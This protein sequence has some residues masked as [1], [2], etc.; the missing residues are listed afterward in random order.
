[1]IINGYCIPFVMREVYFHRSVFYSWF[2]SVGDC[3]YC[4]MSTQ[5]S[6]IA[7]PRLAKRTKE[8]VLAE[9][10]ICKAMNWKLEFL[11]GGYGIYSF[12]E[13]LDLFKDVYEIMG[14]KLWLNVGTLNDKQL[15]SALPYIEGV[16][17]T[18]ESVN[19]KIR[20][21]MCPSKPMSE[22]L[23]MFNL[24]NKYNLK[25][26]I[27]III[28]LGETFD[29]YPNLKEFINKH[30]IDQVTFYRLK[31]IKETVFEKT[32]PIKKEYLAKWVKQTR[33]DFPNIK[34]ITGTD[35]LHLDDISLML[36]SGADG[37]TKFPSIKKFNSAKAH[38]FKDEVE[39]AGCKFVSNFTDSIPD[40]KVNNPKI[41][42]KI[43]EYVNQMN[44]KLKV[45]E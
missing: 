21:E 24:C 28:G 1:M 13:L 38:Q 2:C 8:S 10:H 20:E 42:E 37:V 39:A 33:I 3:K 17:G 16:A 34:I 26:A 22:I 32:E 44:S 31:P 43:D 25:K 40:I 19:W 18:V 45:L 23:N 15:E 14:E 30:N 12:P 4:Y 5:R 36:K 41:Q 29:D 35:F 9:V 27:T 11:S 7:D 6:K